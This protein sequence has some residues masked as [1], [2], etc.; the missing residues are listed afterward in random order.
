MR[1]L[2]LIAI[3][4]IGYRFLKSWIAS[5]IKNRQ[6]VAG[7]A[8]RKIDD[9]MIKDPLCGVYFPKRHSVTLQLDGNDL[10]FCSK[11]CR[12][13]YLATHFKQTS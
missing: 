6:S 3:F 12:D 7:N 9:V 11:Q 5:N 2:I 1:V 4:Y 13:E 10:F 8:V